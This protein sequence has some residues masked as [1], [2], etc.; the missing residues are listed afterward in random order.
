MTWVK[1]DG[2]TFLRGKNRDLENQ[3]SAIILPTIL[4]CLSFCAY[5][6]NMA[7]RL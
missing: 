2:Y 1:T 7:A 4:T 3:S 5:L 6:Q